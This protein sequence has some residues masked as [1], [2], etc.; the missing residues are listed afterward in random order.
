M[1][2]ISNLR[3]NAL[4]QVRHMPGGPYRAMRAAL[5]VF[6][7]VILA[8]CGSGIAETAATPTEI[9]VEPTEIASEPTATT[10]APPKSSVQMPP[11]LP[12][13]QPGDQGGPSLPPPAWLVVDGTAYPATY[14]T[15]CYGGGCVDMA[16]PEK[17]PEVKQATVPAGE[18]LKVRIDSH[19]PVELN[20]TIRA[21]G[22]LPTSGGNVG[23][24]LPAHGERVDGTTVYTLEP[25]TD[26]D[27]QVLVAFTRFAK[28]GDASYI[29]RINSSQ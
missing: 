14:G 22:D 25:P 18:E 16:L 11:T 7:L 10:N 5:S 20:A 4:P 6:L 29:W 19:E 26:A 8:G 13:R 1:K 3:R 21:W 2:S 28:G 17:M 12:P 24:T 9:A 15:Y 23:Q 27:D